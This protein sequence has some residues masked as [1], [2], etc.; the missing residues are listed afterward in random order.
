L[1]ASERP[2]L[3]IEILEGNAPTRSPRDHRDRCGQ[4]PHTP[5]QKLVPLT[6]A[7]SYVRRFQT[8]RRFPDSAV[9]RKPRTLT[10]CSPQGTC[11]RTARNLPPARTQ[12]NPNWVILR[13]VQLDL[14]RIAEASKRVRFLPTVTTDRFPSLNHRKFPEWQNWL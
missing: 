3:T 14:T 4:L 7:R 10:P 12:V 1:P 9:T 6:P 13:P 5:D 11:L 8:P 2:A